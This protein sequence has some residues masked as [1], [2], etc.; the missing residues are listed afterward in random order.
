MHLLEGLDLRHSIVEG[1]LVML[2]RGRKKPRTQWPKNPGPRDQKASAL[3]LC[4][5]RNPN[6]DQTRAVVVAQLVE[7]LL[8]TPEIHGSNPDIGKILFTNCTIEKTKIMK[9]RPRMAHL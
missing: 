5:N 8:P 1:K 2:D 7:R 9:K 6:F 4:Y 3:P